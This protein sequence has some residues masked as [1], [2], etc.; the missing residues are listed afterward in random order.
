MNKKIEKSKYLLLDFL[1]FLCLMVIF[2]HNY[3]QENNCIVKENN[4][5]NYQIYLT[6]YFKNIT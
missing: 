6:N 2:P 1:F 5:I 3:G 4:I